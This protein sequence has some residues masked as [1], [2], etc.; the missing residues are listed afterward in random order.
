MKISRVFYF[1]YF[2]F[3]FFKNKCKKGKN[4]KNSLT[5]IRHYLLKLFIY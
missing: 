5:L 3:Y 4:E 2:F 1:Y